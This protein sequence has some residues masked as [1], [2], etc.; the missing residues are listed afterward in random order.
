MQG[1]GE[2]GPWS[3]L[4]LMCQALFKP[5][6]GYSF[7]NGDRGGVDGEGVYRSPGEGTG[8]EESGETVLGM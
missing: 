7:W 3:Y 8:E 1:V 5:M 2:E 4:N 6:G